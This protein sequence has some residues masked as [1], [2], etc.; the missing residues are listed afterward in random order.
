MRH[1]APLEPDMEFSTDDSDEELMARVTARDSAAF[2]RLYDR[3]APIALGIIVRIIQDRA[4]GE[5]VLQESFWR[6]WTQA[7]TYDSEKGPFRAWLFSIARRQALDL[8]R[9]RNVRPQAARDESEERRYEQAPAS[10]AA[11][12][13]VAE[14]AIAAQQVRGALVRLSDEQFQVL[15]LA[16]FK[17]L[18]RQEIAQT[19]GLP[20]GTVHTRARLG[21]Q[22]LRSILGDS[23]GM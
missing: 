16:F 11:V 23:G 20:L 9:R 18:T 22:K 13:D 8:L 1:V 15:E 3:Y 2:E 14:Q 10:D 6:V 5:E 17:G 21:L 4:E 7:A 12:P 19:T